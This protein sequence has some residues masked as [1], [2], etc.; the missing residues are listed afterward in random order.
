MINAAAKV[1]SVLHLVC[2]DS[3]Q[4]AAVGGAHAGQS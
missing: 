1:S 4:M 2:T 3:L